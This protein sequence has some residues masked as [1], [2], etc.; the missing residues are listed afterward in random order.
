MAEAAAESGSVPPWAAQQLRK[1]APVIGVVC[2]G[3]EAVAPVCWQLG[4]GIHAFVNKLPKPAIEGLAGV[5]VCFYG[6]RYT[7]TIAAVEAFKASGGSQTMQYLRDLWVQI[8]LVRKANAADDLED[9]DR[10][11]RADVTQLSPRSLWR[12][13]VTLVMKT[14]DPQVLMDSI[15]GLWSGYMGVLAV[16]KFQFARTV[17]LAH[18][19]GDLMRP[20]AAKVFAPTLL[21]L[22][23]REYHRW[24]NPIV[25]FGCKASA[26]FVAWKIQYTISTFQSGIKGGLLAAR[27]FLPYIYH[28]PH[29]DTILDEIIGYSL[30]ATGIYFQF[31]YGG[32]PL[33]SFA[34][35]LLWP[36]DLL[37]W[38][39]Q[40][41]VTWIAKD[42]P[43]L[44]GK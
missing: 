10:D 6:G 5:G 7:V 23:P 12:R 13:K 41:S 43:E 14:V 36:L 4:V 2:A 31:K 33:P 38:W 1:A 26:A 8:D 9:R 28:G 40:F 32:L 44:K 39:M 35:P 42:D 22:I 21:A 30:A 25:N 24:V 37:E 19:I 20:A 16:V 29:E 18:S 34:K 17:A 15:G 3:A 11:G 27:G